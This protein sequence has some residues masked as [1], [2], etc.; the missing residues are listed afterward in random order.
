MVSFFSM[1]F[2][3]TSWGGRAACWAACLPIVMAASACGIKKSVEVAIPP[4]I[5]AARTATVDEM[6]T[7]LHKTGEAIQSLRSTS[8]R[9]TLTIG[10]AESGELVQYRSAPGYILLRRPDSLRLNIGLPVT[11]TTILEL[12]SVGDQF[13]IWDP[14]GNR[15]FMG[16]NSAGE[17]DLE[18]N[19][20]TPS[21]S[22]RPNQIFQAILPPQISL[23]RPDRRI[24]RTEEQD[25]EAKYYVLTLFEDTGGPEIRPLRRFWIER[26]EMALTKEETFTE[27]G[28]IAST[29]QYSNMSDFDGVRLP[30]SILIDRPADGYRLDLQFREWRVNPDLPD[31]AFALEQPPKSELVV[32]KEKGKIRSQ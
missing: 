8:V 14:R 10:K 27:G 4:K 6:L 28:Q 17:F 32:L 20:R 12:A 24:S 2:R 23:D 18:D 9:V 1:R 3:I 26:S 15:F 5:A 30:L 25:E 11:N 19:I 13:E 22:A 16:R 29:V 21:F 31:K 7:N